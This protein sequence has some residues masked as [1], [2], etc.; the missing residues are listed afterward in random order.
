MSPYT[1]NR[2]S[3]SQSPEGHEIVPVHPSHRG[4]TYQRKPKKKKKKKRAVS[5]KP[6]EEYDAYYL[7]PVDP[8]SPNFKH[9]FIEDDELKYNAGGKQGAQNYEIAA[10]GGAE[11]SQEG[12]D[13]MEQ[14]PE[15]GSASGGKFGGAGG[16]S[17]REQEDV[18]SQQTA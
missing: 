5:A 18:Q 13:D 12:M 4:S 8:N 17:P 1:P 11:G 10:Y 16:T 9:R 2:R 14:A 6:K 7:A 3:P 15:E